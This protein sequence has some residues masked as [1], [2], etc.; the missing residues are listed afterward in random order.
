MPTR[1]RARSAAPG[2]PAVAG[3]RETRSAE[4]RADAVDRAVDDLGVDHPVEPARA[5]RGP[6]RRP[7]ARCRRR[8]SRRCRGRARARRA[9][10][11]AGRRS[12]CSRPSV[13]RV[14]EEDP[15]ELRSANVSISSANPAD[16]G[17]GVGTSGTPRNDGSS[18]LSSHSM[19]VNGR[20]DEA[21]RSRR[22]PR[23]P[24][25]GSTMIRGDSCGA[26]LDRRPAPGRRSDTV[27]DGSLSS[28]PS[29]S[30]SATLAAPCGVVVTRAARHD[31]ARS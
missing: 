3:R 1:C 13:E 12:A 18:H 11:R 7:A 27:G 24:R 23:A 26:W 25:S 21:R 8:S 22:A 9:S 19:L 5:P 17:V 16:E 30:S 15:D 28:S 2:R 4:Q 14:R 29:V 31:R 10:R 6:G 20:F